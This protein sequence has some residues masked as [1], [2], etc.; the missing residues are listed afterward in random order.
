MLAVIIPYFN[1]VGYK[2]RLINCASTY[3]K[4]KSLGVHSVVCE[5]STTDTFKLDFAD[6]RLKSNSVL[7][8]KERIINHVI[9]TLP[10]EYDK[11]AWIDADVQPFDPDWPALVEKALNSYDIVQPFS[12]MHDLYYAGEDCDPDVSHSLTSKTPIVADPSGWPGY[13]WAARREAMRNGLYDRSVVGGGDLVFA[14]AVLGINNRWMNMINTEAEQDYLEWRYNLGRFKIGMIDTKMYHLWHG[15]LSDRKYY[16]R[17]WMLRESEFN[18]Q[19]DLVVNEC[20]MYEFAGNKPELELQVL[21]YFVGRKE[22][23]EPPAEAGIKVI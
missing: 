12:V 7:F 19:V 4:Y 10:P 5:L 18:P 8:H 23:G 11:V 6:Y 16:E 3:Y 2:N 1:H 13:A 15:N 14:E 9:D 17:I 22:D 20:G 21:N